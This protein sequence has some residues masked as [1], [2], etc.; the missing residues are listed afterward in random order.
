M[1]MSFTIDATDQL[2]DAVKKEEISSGFEQTNAVVGRSERLLLYANVTTN[3][4]NVMAYFSAGP[5]RTLSS[6]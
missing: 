2:I 4:A 1:L 6:L 3:D 5:I